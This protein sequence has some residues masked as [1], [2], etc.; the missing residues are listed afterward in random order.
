MPF[1]GGLQNI[2]IRE[3]NKN[4]YNKCLFEIKMM[5]H[6]TERICR[7]FKFETV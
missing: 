4:S 6:V 7:R 2:K 1:I 3:E 5:F